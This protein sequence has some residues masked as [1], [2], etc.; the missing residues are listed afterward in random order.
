MGGFIFPFFDSGKIT[1]NKLNK[2]PK[3]PNMPAATKIARFPKCD[4]TKLIKRETKN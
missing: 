3:A 4:V 1:K 2:Y